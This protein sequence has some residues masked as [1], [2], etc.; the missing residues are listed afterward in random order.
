MPRRRVDRCSSTRKLR[1]IPT[2]SPERCPIRVTMTA[3]S[4]HR[5]SLYKR[6]NA[7]THAEGSTKTKKIFDGA[8]GIGSK[9]KTRKARG[10]SDRG[11]AWLGREK[12]VAQRNQGRHCAVPEK[13]AS[14]FIR[15]RTDDGPQAHQASPQRPG[16][17]ASFHPPSLSCRSLNR[18]GPLGLKGPLMP[19]PHKR[20]RR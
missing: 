10:V 11:G 3:H 4:Q 6:Y 9:P 1:E 15:N 18:P 13:H 5:A 14:M 20:H 7:S 12:A 17:S 16:W 19:I 8:L 2:R